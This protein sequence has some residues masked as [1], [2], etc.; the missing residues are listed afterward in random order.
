[1]KNKNF[2]MIIGLV[3][4]QIVFTIYSSRARSQDDSSHQLTL[5]KGWE[6]QSS[7]KVDKFGDVISTSNFVPVNWYKTSVPAT[8]LAV[9]VDNKVYP[10]PYFGMNLRSLPGANYPLN[11]NFSNLPMS[12]DS[13]FRNSWWY[14]TEFQ[15][16]SDFENKALQLHFKGINFRANIWLN[17]KL[18]ADS[19]EV[20]GTFR[21]YEFAINDYA[22][23]SGTNYLAVEVFAPR[24]D[25]LAIT[26]VE[27]NPAPPDKNMGIWHDVVI[28]ATGPVTIRYPQVV[29]EFDLPSLDVAH[30]T[31]SSELQNTIN[32]SV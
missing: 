31:I 9:L 20:A 12:D 2:N 32:Q 27:W 10:D 24:K 3:L 11:S 23:Y 6:I 17:G 13:P 14:R 25:D 16:P 29:T 7:T 4:I 19:G 28:T 21:V 1:M 22:V 30:L 5:T 15:L 18:L 26:W 8:V